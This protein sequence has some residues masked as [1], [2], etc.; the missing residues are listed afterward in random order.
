MST[1][2]SDNGDSGGSLS[3]D[4]LI[5]GRATRVQDRDIFAPTFDFTLHQEAKAAQAYP[6]YQ[7]LE[8]SDGPEAVIYGKRVLMLGSNNYPGPDPPSQGDGSGRG[9]HPALRHLR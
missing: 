3:I 1:Q 9:G 6:F 2:G 8:R 5:Q 7:P 4:R